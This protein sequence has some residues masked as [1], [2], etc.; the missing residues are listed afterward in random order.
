MMT[1]NDIIKKLEMYKNIKDDDTTISCVKAVLLKYSYLLLKGQQAEIELLENE[2]ASLINA[3]DTNEFAAMQELAED[4]KMAFYYEFDELI[5]SVMADKI[6]SLVEKAKERYANGWISVN[7]R[8]PDK[9]KYDWVLISGEFLEGG[10]FVPHVAELRDGVW[11]ASEYERP[12]EDLCAVKV[13][14]WKPLPP[15]PKKSEE[16]SEK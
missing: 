13:T 14:H 4:I 12:F 1:Y 16:S 6:D 8:L 10:Y 9:T 7:D 2:K 3:C 15:D 11:Y 5:P